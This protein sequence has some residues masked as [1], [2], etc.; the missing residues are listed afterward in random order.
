MKVSTS[1]S[2]WGFSHRQESLLRYAESRVLT[3]VY[4]PHNAGLYKS[5]GGIILRLLQVFLIEVVW[6]CGKL[7]VPVRFFFLISAM[8]LP[9]L[10]MFPPG[11]MFIIK[12]RVA[13][14]VLLDEEL[15]LVLLAPF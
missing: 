9:L 6:S 10:I 1:R 11:V 14:P 4:I 3:Y 2:L 12:T 5:V 7:T 8:I 13:Y 15:A